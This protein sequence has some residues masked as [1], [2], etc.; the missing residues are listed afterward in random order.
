MRPTAEAFIEPSNTSDACEK[1]E[2]EEQMIRFETLSSATTWA[3]EP[4]FFEILKFN[5]IFRSF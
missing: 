5:L 2:L 4:N 1:D 3:P